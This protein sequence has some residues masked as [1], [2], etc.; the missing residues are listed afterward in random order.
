MYQYHTCKKYENPHSCVRQLCQTMRRFSP[1]IGELPK[2]DQTILRQIKNMRC[3]SFFRSFL[4]IS[5]KTHT[6]HYLK[7]LFIGSFRYVEFDNFLKIDKN[8]DTSYALLSD[9]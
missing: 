8:M 1:I 2:N 4:V 3:A 7:W 9:K 5:T 6:F